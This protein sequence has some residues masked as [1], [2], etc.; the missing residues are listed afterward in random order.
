[1]L[2][3]EEININQ[4]GNNI[5]RQIKDQEDQNKANL[6]EYD[7]QESYYNEIIAQK[8][9]FLLFADERKEE[10]KKIAA[11]A[12]NDS[13]DK[14][15]VDKRHELELLKIYNQYLVEK[16]DKQFKKYEKLEE[17]YHKIC[18]ITG[19]KDLN[20]IVDFIISKEKKYNKK[21]LD[22]KKKENNIK[23]L[24]E[25]LNQKKEELIKLKNEI[26]VKENSEGEKSISTIDTG[27]LDQEEYDLYEKEIQLDKEL[28]IIGSKHNEI[29]LSYTKV[30]ENIHNVTTQ[31]FKCPLM[32]KPLAPNDFDEKINNEI[33]ED[34]IHIE[35]EDKENNEMKEINDNEVQENAENQNNETIPD[36]Q[37]NQENQQEITPETPQEYID[38]KPKQ[39]YENIELTE[40][41][42]TEIDHY[43]KFLKEIYAAFEALFLLKNKQD[44]LEIMREKGIQ[45]ISEGK[46]E[47]K[48]PTRN[49]TR[50][51]TKNR[52]KVK[53]KS[54]NNHNYVFTE[55]TKILDTNEEEDKN[56]NDPDKKILV[57]F[58]KEHNKE[59]DDFIRE[60]EI[61]ALKLKQQKK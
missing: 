36:N 28:K 42:K 54:K 22:I 8:L 25:K 6:K 61:A 9:S 12:K 46:S 48:K 51:V 24:K 2:K 34:G 32:I 43:K 59:I 44:F 21:S 30:L 40:K 7:L 45:S 41:E 55:P 16:C 58:M 39:E 23:L 52:T 26:I 47:M 33:H 1:M 38:N 35:E 37:E 18:N 5:H 19:T 15:E 3:I 4:K 53:T 29:D 31:Y 56:N 11:Q 57:K 20:K 49:T 13:M 50:R 17:I 27:K 60:K 14:Q 10:Q